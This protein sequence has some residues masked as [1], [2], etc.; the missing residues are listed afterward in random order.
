MANFMR[1]STEAMKRDAERIQ[2]LNGAI[3]V[4]IEELDNSMQ[5]LAACWEGAAWGMF[6]KNIA[7]YTEM[8]GEIHKYM[9]EYASNM[10]RASNEYMHAEQDVLDLVKKCKGFF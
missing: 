2:E 9:S 1:V 3:P 6:Q 5:Q 10:G 7:D 8:L 4:L